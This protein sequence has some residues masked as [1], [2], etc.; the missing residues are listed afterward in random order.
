MLLL[1]HMQCI[2]M[3]SITSI[4][5]DCCGDESCHEVCFVVLMTIVVGEQVSKKRRPG[6][7]CRGL[8]STHGVLT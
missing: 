1:V 4:N 8:R 6:V 3:F 2:A 5:I 7:N